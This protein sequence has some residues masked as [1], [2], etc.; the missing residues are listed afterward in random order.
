MSQ[1][2]ELKAAVSLRDVASVLG[3]RPAAL[4]YLLY[5]QAAASKYRQ[6]DIPKRY[7]GTRTICAPSVQLKLLQRR[8]C[9][10]LQNCWDEINDAS[11]VSDNISHGFKRGH[12]IISNAKGHRN[13]RYVF[14]V[15]LKDFFGTINFGRVRGYFIKDKRF[16]LNPRVATVLAQI[17]CWN[18][19]LPQGSPCSP[20]ISNLVGHILDIN[21]VRLAARH[22]CTYSRYADDLTFSTNKPVFPAPIA[23]PAWDANTWIP[24]TGLARLITKC[25]FETNP[26]KTRMQYRDS[27]QEVTGLVVN[28]KL[29]V[30]AEYRHTVRAMVHRLITTGAFE[31][32]RKEVDA[33]GVVTLQRTPGTTNQL[34]GMLG[35]I[36]SVDLYNKAK[37]R[38]AQKKD[39]AHTSSKE[40]IYRL[41]LLFKEFYIASRPTIMCEGKTDNIY[42]LYAI[43]S[44]AKSYPQL[45]AINSDNT[46]KLKV[47]L[48]KYTETSTGRILG[49][50]GG[51]GDLGR[52]ICAYHSTIGRFK[53]PGMDHPIM[54]LVDNDDAGRKIFSICKQITKQPVIGNESFLHV[55]G[56]LYVVPTPLVAGKKHSTIEDFFD[57]T[58]KAT[59]VSG[60]TFNPTDDFDPDTHYG[61]AVFAH[62]VI[63]PHADTVDFTAFHEL[64]SNI[65]SAISDHAKRH[66][67]PTP[68][69]E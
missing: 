4:S 24:G 20:V 56:N 14:N 60:K 35:F 64:L 39:H 17:A 54:L 11:G 26:Y 16:H 66:S 43:R 6:F 61:K 30:R 32:I 21:L 2:K 62:K 44:L 46:V 9:D 48:Y 38:T 69:T 67:L 59:Q 53:A 31:F 10:V 65:V 47:R 51:A 41:F 8:L 13:R 19:S 57:A 68:S 40:S 25:G 63:R 7:G 5:T 18:D 1:L 33:N 22:G 12:S 42:L 29:N 37:A 49:I 58:I 55:T 36:D 3:F 15:D 34:H 50:N 27:R 52:F 45:A 23:M 28:C